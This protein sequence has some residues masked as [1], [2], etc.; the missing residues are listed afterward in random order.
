MRPLLERHFPGATYF[1]RWDECPKFTAFCP[2][3]GLTRLAGT[4]VD[5][6][7]TSESYLQP[8]PDKLAHWRARLDALVPAGL[9][10]VAIA[11]AGR[12][13]HNNDRNRSVTLNMLAPFGAVPGIALV[14]VQKGPPAAQA[15]QWQGPAPLISLDAELADFEDTAAVL[16][17]VDLLVC[18]D[19]SVGHLTGALGRPAWVMLPYAPDWRWLMARSDSPWYPSLRLFRQPA[20]RAWTPLIEAV[21]GELTAFAAGS[22]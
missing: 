9:K 8:L 21:A 19:T 22:R 1:S 11:W 5:N 13:T 6:V 12:P 17:S 7:P 18:V 4:R 15:A 14:A 3:S 20:P 16:A 2:F 10:R